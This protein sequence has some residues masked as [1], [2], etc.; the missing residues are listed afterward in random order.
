MEDLLKTLRVKIVVIIICFSATVAITIALLSFFI[1]RKYLQESQQQSAYINLQLLGNELNAAL[2]SVQTFTGLLEL[3]SSVEDYLV[4]SLKQESG[5]GDKDY[6]K[7]SLDTWN[8]LSDEYRTNPAHD[9]INRF[10]ISTPDGASFLHIVRAQ[11]NMVA[12]L[13]ENILNAPFF[14]I[15]LNAGGYEYIGPVESPA[16]RNGGLV[17]PLVRPVKSYDTSE[18]VGFIYV[19]AS[20][21]TLT[22]NLKNLELSKD[23][24]LYMSFNDSV[25]QYENGTFT[26]ASL[27]DGVVTYKLP[28]KN[29]SLSLLPSKNELFLRTRIYSASILVVLFLIII[30][31]VLISVRL[32]KMIEV[33]VE[34]LI[35][36]KLSHER[37]KQALE[38]R[39]LQEQI[40]PHFMYNTLNT[41]KWMAT[42]QGADGI[43]DMSTALSR[44]LKN[45]AKEEEGLIHLKDE[46]TLLDDYFTIMK[47]R[48]GGTIE[49]TYDI[50]DKRLLSCLINRF[51]LQPV[52][53]NAIFHGIEPK[54]SAGKIVIKIYSDESR[55]Y[56]DVTDNGVGMDEESL[57]RLMDGTDN[58]DND[59][60]KDIGIKN[61]QERIRF[62]FGPEYGLSAESKEGEYTTIHFTLPM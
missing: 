47:Y 59:F 57:K 26:E 48:Y 23:S 51:S 61:V 13:T 32:R 3:D 11:S 27:P 43:A 6:N 17:L 24:A 22:E 12:N 29:I 33:P 28:D 50:Q 4:L 5:A 15:L 41:I 1:S 7:H 52:V 37:E 35:Q 58:T 54:G 25:W 20:F 31:G 34:A 44:L 53:E 46:I 36:E 14:D 9:L 39:I 60:F 40:N 62:S 30:S 56:I 10:V 55:L 16:E 45:I 8:H 2:N 49:L 19:E 18:V 21:S 42:I 38:Y